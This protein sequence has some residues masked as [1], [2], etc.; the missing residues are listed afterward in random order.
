VGVLQQMNSWCKKDGI[1]LLMEHG[2]S[3][4]KPIQW[5]QHAYNPLQYRFIGCHADRNI[6]K[7]IYQAGLKIEKCERKFMGIIYLIWAKPVQVGEINR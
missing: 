3:S 7:L 4:Y 6:L 5:L 1:I 2:Q